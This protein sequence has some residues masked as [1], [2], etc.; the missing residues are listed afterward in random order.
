MIRCNYIPESGDID[1]F[2]ESSVLYQGPSPPFECDLTQC[3]RPLGKRLIFDREE[4]DEP[5]DGIKVYYLKNDPRGGWNETYAIKVTFNRIAWTH[6]RVH[7]KVGSR[8][9][10]AHVNIHTE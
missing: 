6:L 1:I 5:G 7:G 3:G 2:L 8:H 9:G 10:D 4:F